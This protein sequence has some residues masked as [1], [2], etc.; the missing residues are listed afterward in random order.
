M[1]S[2]SVER[3][4][5]RLEATVALQSSAQ[6]T[7]AWDR[8]FYVGMSLVI[9]AVVVYGF[10]FTIDQNLLH[11]SSPRPPILY[12]HAAVFSSWLLF[13]IAQTSLVRGRNVKAHRRLGWFG[14]A[15]GIAIPVLGVATAIAMGKLRLR[16]GTPD[17]L[18]SLIVPLWDMVAFT[19]A[20][21]PAFACRSR[22]EVHRRLMLIA[23]CALTAA[24][25]GRFP[26]SLFADNWFYAGVDA[27]ILLGVARDL[28][29]TKRVHAVYRYGLPLMV[30]GQLVVMQ[31]AVRG[32]SAWLSIAGALLR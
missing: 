5:A 16:E 17:V 21:V 28:V 13:L 1:L 20:F 9:T 15:L 4:L 10:S 31:P 8:S 12:L 27:L 32:S 11:P 19:S 26:N 3:G 25:F 6:R 29:A 14:L 23:S 7:P 18:Q 24:A 30:L 2:K 22:P